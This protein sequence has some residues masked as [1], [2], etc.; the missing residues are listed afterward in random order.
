MYE[1]LPAG[2]IQLIAASGLMG[3]LI[4]LSS[5]LLFAV[6]IVTLVHRKQRLSLIYLG[7]SFLPMFL[8]MIGTF[9]GTMGAFAEHAHNPAANAADIAAGIYVSYMPILMGSMISAFSVFG[10]CLCLAFAKGE[11]VAPTTPPAK[12]PPQSIPAANN[13][14]GTAPTTGEASHGA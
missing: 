13:P 14:A 6:F 5:F 10:A 8:G 1:D 4:C 12:Q 11:S 7:L 9:S 3:W 2:P